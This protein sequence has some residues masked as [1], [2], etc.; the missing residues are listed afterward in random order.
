MTDDFQRFLRENSERLEHER[1]LRGKTLADCGTCGA[2]GYTSP[3]R[4]DS[5]AHGTYFVSQEDCRACAGRGRVEVACSTEQE[6]SAVDREIARLVERRKI[7]LE[8]GRGTR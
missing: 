2:R 8:S 3:S 4:I 5:D 7:L 6:I 1:N